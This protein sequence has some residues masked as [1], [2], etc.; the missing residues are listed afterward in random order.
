MRGLLSHQVTAC[1]PWHGGWVCEHRAL[2]A[3]RRS[4][5]EAERGLGRSRGTRA[6]SVGL[7]G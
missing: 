4:R 1:Q 3:A 6:E 7:W 2:P 5:K